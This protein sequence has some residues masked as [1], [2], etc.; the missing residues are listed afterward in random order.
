MRPASIVNFERFYLGSLAVSLV[1]TLITWDTT[2]ATVAAASP[3]EVG[4]GSG[5]VLFSV[6]FGIVITL[7]LWYFVARRASVVAKWIVVTFFVL[8]LISLVA[9][10]AGMSEGLMSPLDLGLSLVATG[11]EAA[12]V[13]M[14]FRRDAKAWFA[15][16]SESQSDIFS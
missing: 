6:V 16:R 7:L 13:W 12:A 14:L 10:L 9:S 11:L 4:F 15:G 3:P 2:V 8:A 5:F 1:S